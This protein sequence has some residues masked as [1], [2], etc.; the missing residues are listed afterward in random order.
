MIHFFATVRKSTK[1]QWKEEC[2]EAFKEVK[3]FLS[4]PK[5]LV[6]LRVNQPLMLYLLVSNKF[7]SLVLVQETEK[8]E[9]PV[10]FVGKV[11]KEA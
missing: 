1:F 7:I 3:R 10:Y 5:I 2:E 11:L 9:K 4:T 6:R 8:G